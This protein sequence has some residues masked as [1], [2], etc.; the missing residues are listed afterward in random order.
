MLPAEEIHF[1][2]QPRRNKPKGCNP[3]EARGQA[4]AIVK[5]P[6][7]WAISYLPRH[8]QLNRAVAA[9]LILAGKRLGSERSQSEPK[10]PESFPRMVTMIR[11]G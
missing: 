9:A 4:R 5:S 10:Y 7:S 3:T 6:S 11:P 1:G 8:P 2:P